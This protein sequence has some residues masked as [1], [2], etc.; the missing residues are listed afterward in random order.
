VDKRNPKL[1]LITTDRDISF[2]G[3]TTVQKYHSYNL[4]MSPW[5]LMDLF[6]NKDKYGLDIDYDPTIMPIIQ[7]LRNEVKIYKDAKKFKTMSD[8]DIDDLWEVEGIEA[9]F[10]KLKAD[11]FQKRVILWC[12]F[13]KKGG[14]YLEQG[15]GKTIVGI[16]L[17]GKL[18]ADGLIE[19]PLVVAPVSLLS[20]TAWF[21]DLASFSEFEPIN[22]RDPEDFYN[23]T[24]H[25]NFVNPD[26]FQHWCFHKTK[27]AE[28]SYNENNYFEM[29]RF[30]AVFFDESSALKTHSSYRT[31]A[32]IN[33]SKYFKYMFLASGT[34][35]P[36]KIFQIWGQM[37]ALGSVL[38][39]NYSQFEMRYGVKR[40]VGPTELWFPAANAEMEI[41]KRI[42]LVTYWVKRDS[43]MKLP[44]RF[45]VEEPI[46]LHPEHYKLYQKIEKDYCAAA[47]GLDENGVELKGEIAVQYELTVRIKLLQILGGFVDLEDENGKKTRVALPWNAKLDKMDMDIEEHLAN[48]ENNVIIWCRFRWEVETIYKR[49][50]EKY[51]A[52]YI[53]GGMG[54]KKREAQLKI[55]L[56]PESRLIVGIAKSAKFGHTWLKANLMLFYSAT[57]DYEDYAQS[58][59]RNY[60]RGQ[61]REVIEKRYVSVKTIER[62]IWYAL[63]SRKKIDRF[64]K[65]Y[66]KGIKYE[67]DGV[68]T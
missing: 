47:N 48:P 29:R 38:G 57:E 40:K 65:D 5:N 30:D 9:L 23:P 37:R 16:I 67:S 68:P 6:E 27:D 59:D 32:F 17:L 18:M 12:L 66:F 28:H 33:L 46:T 24:G 20:D 8:D 1:F 49:Y 58:H 10:P 14:C 22:L 53:Y 2:L 56:S 63:Q 55:W 43:V 35:A 54:D 50:K 26:K 39:D 60:R 34:P 15:L 21:K 19:K 42:D 11:P 64:L 31:R 45:F 51:N 52:A 25:I 36:N 4:E 7:S 41:R 44:T 62:K 13:V 61:T 3:A